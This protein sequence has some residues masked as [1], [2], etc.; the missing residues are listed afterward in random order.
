MS[1]YDKK[2]LLNCHKNLSVKLDTFLRQNGLLIF[3]LK[4][5]LGIE[6]FNY[7]VSVLHYQNIDNEITEINIG[8]PFE[9]FM[10]LNTLMLS[11]L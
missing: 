9:F 1:F 8:I 2:Y 4:E 5:A 11:K 10:S 3:P 6:S 7:T